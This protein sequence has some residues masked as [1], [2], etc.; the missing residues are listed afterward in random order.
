MPDEPYVMM[1]RLV[2]V[3]TVAALLGLLSGLV[4]WLVF[5]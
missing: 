5:S 3:L 1:R 4:Y 2:M